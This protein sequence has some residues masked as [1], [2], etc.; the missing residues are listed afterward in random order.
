MTP[1]AAAYKALA[2]HLRTPPPPPPADRELSSLYPSLPLTAAAVG[3]DE[4]SGIGE[5]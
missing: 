5:G 2:A 3:R 4:G 1:T